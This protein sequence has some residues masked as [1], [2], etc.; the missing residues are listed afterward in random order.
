MKEL[1]KRIANVLAFFLVLFLVSCEKDFDEI[2]KNPNAIVDVAAEYLLPGSIMSISNEENGFMQSL[3]YAS[4][5]VQ[6]TSGGSWVDP[7]RYY[8]EKSRVY[9][10]NNLYSGPLM[11]L[12]VMKAKAIA[13]NNLALKAV[14]MILQAYGNSMLVDVYGH[15]PY[16][17]ALL[18][19]SGINKPIFDEGE[20]VYKSLIDSLSSANE[21]LKD[22]ELSIN[23][24]YD[25]LFSGSTLSWR[26]FCNSLKLRLLVR[27]SQ[28][29]E[30]YS[31]SYL[32]DFY[33]NPDYPLLESNDDNIEFKYPA[34]SVLTYNPLHDALSENSSDGGYRVSNSLV[35]IMSQ[36]EDPRL[37]VYATP[38][39][40]GE[41]LGLQ[42]GSSVSASELDLYAKVAPKY[43][44]EDRPGIFM[45]YSE[46]SFLLAEAA[47]KSLINAS[48]EE[49]YKQAIKANFDDLGLSTNA[50]NQ[51]IS[52]PK[53]IY[54]GYGKLMTQKWISLYG[55]G[56]EAWIEYKR[57]GIPSLSIA[58]Y[59][60]L[61]SIPSRFLYP[62]SE[63]QSNNVN[64]QE[65]ISKLSN[66]DALDSKIW[67]MN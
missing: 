62:L 34:N 21:I 10:W 66:G 67:W 55:R 22:N 2:N 56:I 59:A 36:L 33:N 7:G 57:T 48:A 28:K 35:E 46:V 23:P 11:D 13:D 6:H 61:E 42:N 37:S 24:E 65:A 16:T 43:G 12:S 53:L 20:F 44:A 17:E 38:N 58:L 41:I 25:V 63:E 30:S 5:W 50:Y 51:Y 3:V 40:N 14:A 52:S 4:D 29:S 19:E 9:M 32:T 39:E 27:A 49:L 1:I 18:A 45:T 54:S 64:L 60:N 15:I 8:F 31:Q 26:K 47:E